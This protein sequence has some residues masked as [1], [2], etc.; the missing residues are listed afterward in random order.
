[1]IKERETQTLKNKIH[2]NIK[3]ENTVSKQK[4]SKIK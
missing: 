2:E 4:T 3:L 1:M